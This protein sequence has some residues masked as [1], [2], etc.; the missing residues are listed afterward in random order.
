MKNR[1][2]IEEGDLV[3]GSC[4]LSRTWKAGGKH[5]HWKHVEKAN[6]CVKTL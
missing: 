4:S 6:F 2:K 5:A 3:A 1:V